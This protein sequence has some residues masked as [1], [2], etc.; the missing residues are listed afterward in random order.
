V[1]LTTYPNFRDHLSQHPIELLIA[2]AATSH[3]AH[4]DIRRQ[5]FCEAN[6]HPP[7]PSLH[8]REQ[9]RYRIDHCA[10]HQCIDKAG[11]LTQLSQTEGF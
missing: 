11:D 3:D 5:G 4:L 10:K 2:D 7:L 1:G 9:H 6:Q 8:Q